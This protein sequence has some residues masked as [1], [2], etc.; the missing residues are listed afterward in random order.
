MCCVV[1]VAEVISMFLGTLSVLLYTYIAYAW[2][3]DY[4]NMMDSLTS[5]CWLFANFVWMSG[6]I[7]IRC[8]HTTTSYSYH[9]SLT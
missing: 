1:P 5:W 7:F 3:K 2:R 6:E 9:H 4:V 8:Q